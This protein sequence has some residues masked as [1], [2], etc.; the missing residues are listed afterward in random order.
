MSHLVYLAQYRKRL[1]FPGPDSGRHLEHYRVV[2]HKFKIKI[3]NACLA[4]TD[5]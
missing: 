1:V 5:M 4:K 3:K 2:Q